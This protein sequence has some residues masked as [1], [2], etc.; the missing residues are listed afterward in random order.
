[1]KLR[2][3]SGWLGVLSVLF[4]ASPVRAAL[5]EHAPAWARPLA[6]SLALDERYRI[7]DEWGKKPVTAEQLRSASPA[8][9]RAAMATAKLTGGTSF[10]LGHFAGHHVLATNHH[11]C[12]QAWQCVGRS[13]KFPF[14]G[15][16]SFKV[17]KFFGTWSD[18]DLTLVAIEVADWD[19]NAKKELAAVAAN[20]DFRAELY[21]G[22]ALL[23]IG[24]GSGDNPRGVMVGNQD[25]DCK[26]FSGRG[27][28]RFMGDPDAFNPGPYKAWSFA[29]GC[30]VSHGDSGSAMVD[31]ETGRIVGI[32]W[33]G[34]IPKS[35]QVQSSAWLD[36]LLSRGGDEIWTE[37]SYA[38]PAQKIGE[39]LAA[40][41]E[42]GTTDAGAREVLRALLGR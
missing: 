1:M 5:P 15:D 12:P 7:G 18:I 36:Q 19:Q 4:A 25:S 16:R 28:Y 29:N 32:I 20:F 42:S 17:V 21:P 37:L 10:Y 34:K 11:V 9:R 38:V 14:L 13:A 33:T 31:R 3:P 39:V 27:E 22:Q 41:A 35:E 6:T 23:T 8:F 30:D 24:F 2:F 26:V 40:A